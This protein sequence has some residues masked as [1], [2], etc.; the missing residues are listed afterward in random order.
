MKK[1][2]FADL[3]VTRLPKKIELDIYAEDHKTLLQFWEFKQKQ[4]GGEIPL[5]EV[6]GRLIQVVFQD[7]DFAVA[8]GKKDARKSRI[9]KADEQ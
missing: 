1:S 2:V 5:A 4:M 7:S 3:S 9:P 8:V 6:F